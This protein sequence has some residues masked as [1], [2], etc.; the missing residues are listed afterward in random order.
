MGVD[1]THA[2]YTTLQLGVWHVLIAKSGVKL[3]GKDAFSALP[4]LLAFVAEIY[5]LAP[6][7]VVFFVLTKIWTGFQSSLI[8][9]TSN[10]LLTVVS[11]FKFD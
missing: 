2:P 11:N 3:P 1:K 6:D 9:H 5:A 10:H 7:L 8:L 4:L